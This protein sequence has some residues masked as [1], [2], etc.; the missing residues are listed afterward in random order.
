M[1]ERICGK[2]PHYQNGGYCF[3]TG[4]TVGWFWGCEKFPTV[5]PEVKAPEPIAVPGTKKCACCGREL[6]LE[7][8]P[9]HWK[10]KDGH[11]SVCFL[12]SK[13]QGKMGGRP[14]KITE[15]DGKKE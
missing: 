14:K 10:A 7:K 3:K 13:E 1:M 5:E 4:K 11:T 9:K 12:C 2:C 15:S 6:P 8:F